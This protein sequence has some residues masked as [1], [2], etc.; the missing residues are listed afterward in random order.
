MDSSAWPG[1]SL[2]DSRNPLRWSATLFSEA[3]L[4][5]DEPNTVSAGHGILNCGHAGAFDTGIAGPGVC[6]IVSTGNPTQTY[7]ST[8]N[9]YGTF[10]CDGLSGRPAANTFTCGRPN[11]FQARM[12]TA[13][14]VVTFFGVPFDPPGGGTRILRVTNL[15]ANAAALG[16]AGSPIQATSS[17]SGTI[18]VTVNNPVQAVATAH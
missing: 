2:P 12:G 5:V 4:L 9:G 1:S 13:G 17:I 3:L 11:V 18:A 8:P 6:E 15:R 10:S 7:D 16:L 14:N